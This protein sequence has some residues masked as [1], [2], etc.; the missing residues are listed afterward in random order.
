M[1]KINYDLTQ[2][3]GIAFDVD[4]VLSP[5]TVPMSDDGV[6]QRMANLKDGFAMVQAVKCDLKIA[7]ISGAETE[8]VRR[9]FESIGISDIYLGSFDK[10]PV[11]LQWMH[12]H[13]FAPS[14]VAFVGDDIPDLKPMHHV[15]LAV[16]P[17][18]AAPEIK[19]I[20]TYITCANGGYGVAR[21]LI[22][23][24]LRAR[25]LWP[26]GIKPTTV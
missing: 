15:G 8:G 6:P 2:I 20:A 7:I 25:G 17:R 12:Q 24:V 14:Q 18:D 21:E 11:L 10:L 23:Q 3:R 4:G 5:S 13:G 16:A 9:R 26:D 1:S 19:D 22:E